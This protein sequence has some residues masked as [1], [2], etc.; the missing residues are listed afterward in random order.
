MARTKGIGRGGGGTR[1]K[2]TRAGWLW[3]SLLTLAA[4]F[5]GQRGQSGRLWGAR[6]FTL[7]F[8]RCR[9]GGGRG[10]SDWSRR[11]VCDGFFFSFSFSVSFFCGDGSGGKVEGRRGGGGYASADPGWGGMR[12][13]QGGRWRGRRT[14][15]RRGN[16]FAAGGGRVRGKGGDGSGRRYGS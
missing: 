15:R 4:R 12:R 9:N 13:R 1:R 6:S 14:T 11:R 10:Q 5:A 2:V 3:N 8:S 7:S 16:E